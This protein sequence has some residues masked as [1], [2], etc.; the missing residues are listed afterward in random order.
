M[1]LDIPHEWEE[2]LEEVLSKKLSR[3]VII[4][5]EDVGKST[6]ALYLVSRIAERFEVN[7]IDADIGQ[8]DLGPPATITLGITKKPISSLAEMG[9][10]AM[11]FVGSV[12][13][14][15]HLLPQVVGTKLLAERAEAPFLIVNT[16]GF[17]RNAGLA[18][19]SFKIEALGIDAILALQRGDELE[20]ILGAFPHV[21]TFRLPV[22]KKAVRKSAEQRRRHRLQ[23]FRNYFKGSRTVELKRKNLAFQRGSLPEKNLLCGLA[24]EKGELLGLGVVIALEKIS[25]LTP[26]KEEIRI[27][28]LGSVRLQIGDNTTLSEY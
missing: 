28:Q 14:S 19:K 26:V 21:K 25:L 18:L 9:V 4:G 22:S 27:L 8:K 2:A 17:V 7:L 11:Y 20:N 3:V 1:E 24:D 23:A 5:D 10:E 6:L 16:T 15:G 13:P 12:S